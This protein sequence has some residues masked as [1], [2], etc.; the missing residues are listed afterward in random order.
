MSSRKNRSCCRHILCFPCT[1]RTEST[2]YD[3]LRSDLRQKSTKLL[4]KERNKAYKIHQRAA[5]ILLQYK[6]ATPS[7]R[8]KL[9]W[10]SSNSWQTHRS[11]CRELHMPTTTHPL[12]SPKRPQFCKDMEEIFNNGRLIQRS[13]KH[14]LQKHSSITNWSHIQYDKGMIR[15]GQDNDIHSSL[16][17]E[18][19]KRSFYTM[20]MALPKTEDRL[21]NPN[22]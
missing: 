2:T 7:G 12:P 10:P 19:I 9:H 8:L 4:Q 11:I 22:S 16:Q 6:L 13:Q 1:Q 14:S 17:P 5:P 21:G 15:G 18:V 3:K 20:E